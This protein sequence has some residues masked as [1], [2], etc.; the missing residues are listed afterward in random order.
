MSTTKQTAGYLPAAQT[1]KYQHKT[2]VFH[3]ADAVFSNYSIP[4]CNG[5]N[6]VHTSI[7]DATRNPNEKIRSDS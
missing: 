5:D 2:K 3:H 1:N 4:H 6:S 7:Y